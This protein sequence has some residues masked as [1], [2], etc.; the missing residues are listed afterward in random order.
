[1]D[2]ANSSTTHTQASGG[3]ASSVK[4]RA[5]AQLDTQKGR[6][7]DGLRALTQ[8]ARQ[9]T[10]QLRTDQHETLA[11]Y[12]DRALQ[13]LDRLN[14]RIRSKD[15]SELLRD[16]QQLARRQPALFIGGSFLAGVLAARFLKSSQQ[17]GEVRQYASADYPTAASAGATSSERR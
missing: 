3:I 15:V 5:T 6:A 14:D 9:T 12:I 11:N 13:Q 1:M 10:Q 16:A 2:N 4:Q 7:T 8:A 17:D